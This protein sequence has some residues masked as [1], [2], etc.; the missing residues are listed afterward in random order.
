M[1]AKQWTL[2][3]RVR[4]EKREKRG[5]RKQDLNTKYWCEVTCQQHGLGDHDHYG[6]PADIILQAEHRNM[7]VGANYGE[8]PKESI[9]KK[10]KSQS[11][12]FYTKN[13]KHKSRVIFLE[14]EISICILV[15]RYFSKNL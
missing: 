12:S 5:N 11:H 10:K 7:C 9:S 6:T 15:F 4:N 13:Y 8:T 1:L 14:R 2:T 3:T